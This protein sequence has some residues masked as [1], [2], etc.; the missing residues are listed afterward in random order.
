MNKADVNWSNIVMKSNAS[1]VGTPMKLLAIAG[2]GLLWLTSGMAQ[3]PPPPGPNGNSPLDEQQGQGAAPANISPAA[4][5][6]VNLAGSG[7]SEQQLIDRIQSSP[8]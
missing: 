5:D 1:N 3:S 6:I 2:A 8:T 4:A 7:T